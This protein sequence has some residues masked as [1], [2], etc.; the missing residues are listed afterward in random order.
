[1][2]WA[3][4]RMS[5]IYTARCSC[6]RRINFLID[7]FCSQLAESENEPTNFYFPDSI[8]KFPNN[9]FT[10]FRDK[11]SNSALL[12]TAQ[13][14][15]CLLVELGPL[16]RAWRVKLSA[17]RDRGSNGRRNVEQVRNFELEE[18]K[19]FK[20]LNVTP[21]ITQ[22]RY[23]KFN[24]SDHER[25]IISSKKACWAPPTTCHLKHFRCWFHL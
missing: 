14:L 18:N 13:T 19:S 5:L 2:F 21:L 9:S 12:F 22:E 17:K 15:F 4:Y 16:H 3:L 10:F 25:F 7:S 11:N 8:S 20:L 24:K 6:K 1:M 23:T